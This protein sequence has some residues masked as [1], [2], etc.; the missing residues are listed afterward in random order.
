MTPVSWLQAD[1]TPIACNEKLRVLAENQAE[2][3]TTLR[4]VFDDAILMG[5]DEAAMRQILIDEIRA[6]PGPHRR[7][8]PA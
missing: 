8:D 4:D 1:G 3:R 5:V 2:L 6:L 7:A